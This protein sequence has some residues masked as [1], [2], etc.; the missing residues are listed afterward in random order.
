MSY[1]LKISKEDINWSFEN[2]G[3][4]SSNICYYSYI[5]QDF[6]FNTKIQ[7]WM[8]DHNIVAEIKNFEKFIFVKFLKECDAVLFKMNWL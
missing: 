6:E 8:R 2:T 7:Y 4:I 5:K 3:I 1:F